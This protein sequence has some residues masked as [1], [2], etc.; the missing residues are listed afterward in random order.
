MGDAPPPSGSAN[1][2]ANRDPRFQATSQA[3]SQLH[4]PH[5]NSPGGTSPFQTQYNIQYGAH[6]G[7]YP[8]QFEYVQSSASNRPD[9]FDMTAMA[10]SLPQ[11][12]YGIHLYNPGNQQRYGSMN[13]NS[14]G[15]LGQPGSNMAPFPGQ[16]GMP[17]PGTHYFQQQQQQ[18]HQYYA[19]HMHPTQQPA[20]MNPRVFYPHPSQQMPSPYYVPHHVQP[21]AYVPVDGRAVSKS[22]R[23]DE[24]GAAAAGMGSM[25][26][27]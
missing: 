11:S 2:Y 9:N 18:Q 3:E 12:G 25:E 26:G 8:P 7:G 1:A 23:S 20:T 15:G 10:N 21:Q 19:G 16:A 14:R 4:Y 5:G 13:P 24:H 6:H 27:L 17:M 22:T